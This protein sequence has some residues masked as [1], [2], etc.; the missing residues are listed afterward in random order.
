MSN[1]TIQ[2]ILKHIFTKDSFRKNIKNVVYFLCIVRSCKKYTKLSYK[3][4]NVG[5]NCPNKTCSVQTPHNHLIN[6][7]KAIFLTIFL[8]KI[9]GCLFLIWQLKNDLNSKFSEKKLIFRKRDKAVLYVQE[10]W[11][12]FIKQVTRKNGSGLLGHVVY[13]I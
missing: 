13:H 2:F 11:T 10:V 3:S 9:K 1:S 6:H 7:I 12:H 4:N 5:Y 8:F